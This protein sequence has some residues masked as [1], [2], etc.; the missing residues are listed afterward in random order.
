MSEARLSGVQE[1]ARVQTSSARATWSC[2]ESI[3]PKS[4][5]RLRA[6]VCEL[7]GLH[8]LV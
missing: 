3:A 5:L 8:P 1:M 6:Y 7:A 2:G 4:R